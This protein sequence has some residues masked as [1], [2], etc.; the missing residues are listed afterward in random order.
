MGP[1]Q[2]SNGHE[3][4]SDSKQAC[5]YDHITLQEHALGEPVLKKN[6]WKFNVRI[7]QMQSKLHSIHMDRLGIGSKMPISKDYTSPALLGKLDD[8]FRLFKYSKLLY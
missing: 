5:H 6:E 4:T 1:L 2:I 3:K 7:R 8:V